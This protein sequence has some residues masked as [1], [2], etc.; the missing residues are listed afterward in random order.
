MLNGIVAIQNGTLSLT[1][2]SNNNTAAGRVV[3][4]EQ[5]YL[6]D[7]ITGNSTDFTTNFSF[8]ISIIISLGQDG[9]AFLAN[10]TI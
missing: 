5:L 7:P 3:Y 8:K 4:S 2:N 1:S 9:L 6:Y 10:V